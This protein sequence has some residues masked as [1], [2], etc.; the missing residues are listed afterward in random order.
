MR[1]LLAAV[2]ALVNAQC[3]ARC[4]GLSCQPKTPPCHRHQPD[5]QHGQPC[6]SPEWIADAGKTI[7][8]KAQVAPAPAVAMEAMPVPPVMAFIEQST[9]SA[10]SPPGRM[11]PLAPDILRI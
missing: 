4:A 2:L 9:V 8:V 6:A 1:I 11:S 7:P 3:V 5:Q 10:D